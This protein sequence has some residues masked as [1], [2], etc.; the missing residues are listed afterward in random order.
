MKAFH[1]IVEGE[2]QGV[3]F[4]YSAAREARAIGL[5]GWVRNAEDGTV[6]VWAQG[7][8]ANLDLFI[9]WLWQ[10]PSAASVRDVRLSWENPIQSY[11]SFGVVF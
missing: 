4:R 10:G 9:D 7:D 8:P 11:N 2:V 5:C 1:A 6:E 3:G